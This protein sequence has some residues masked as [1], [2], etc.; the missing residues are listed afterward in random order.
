VLLGL[1]QQSGGSSPNQIAVYFFNV[2][3]FPGLQNNLRRLL[4]AVM[5]GECISRFI[6]NN[7][8]SV[9]GIFILCFFC[10]VEPRGVKWLTDHRAAAADLLL[11]G[12]CNVSYPEVR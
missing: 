10:L 9:Y 8:M 3:D 1:Y 4:P 7:L 2:N 5:A 11:P 6:I 12:I